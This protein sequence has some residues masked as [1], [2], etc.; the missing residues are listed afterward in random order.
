M[1]ATLR[2]LIQKKTSNQKVRGSTVPCNFSGK[3][4]SLV[5]RPARVDL[6]RRLGSDL[7]VE[8]KL[9]RFRGGPMLNS[10]GVHDAKKQTAVPAGVSP[11][12]R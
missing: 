3:H 9:T 11:T 6:V 10:E 5:D 12:D 7:V 4:R 1:C 8:L 2:A